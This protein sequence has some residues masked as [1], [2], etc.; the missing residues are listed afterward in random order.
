MVLAMN[1]RDAN[2]SNWVVTVKLET[3]SK[4]ILD[5][6]LNLIASNV[7]QALMPER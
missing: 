5:H 7:T 1:T 2:A 3:S 4:L 6:K